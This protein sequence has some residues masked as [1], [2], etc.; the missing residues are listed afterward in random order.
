MAKYLKEQLLTRSEP[1]TCRMEQCL[2]NP[3]QGRALPV[4]EIKKL[5]KN[6]G[7]T[8]TQKGYVNSRQKRIHSTRIPQA[9]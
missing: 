9:G 8:I 3:S 1:R 5:L 6:E 7:I 4:S 2:P